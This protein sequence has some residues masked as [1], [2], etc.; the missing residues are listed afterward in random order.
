MISLGVGLLGLLMAGVLAGILGGAIVA[1]LAWVGG[2]TTAIA[3]L[4]LMGLGAGAGGAVQH[5]VSQQVATGLRPTWG[6]DT[7]V[8]V[9]LEAEPFVQLPSGH[10]PRAVVRVRGGATAP[11]DEAELSVEQVSVR[12]GLAE[13]WRSGTHLEHASPARVSLRLGP[14]RLQAAAEQ[15]LNR[16][17]NQ[18]GLRISVPLLGTL[19]PTLT[20]LS[21]KA[22]APAGLVFGADL[23]GLP[24]GF[25]GPLRAAGALAMSADGGA[26]G[27]ML[28]E[29][30]VSGKPM[31]RAMLS[32]VNAGLAELLMARDLGLP[33]SDWRF[34]SVE[35]TA[36]GS[37]KLS[38][39]GSVGPGPLGAK[40]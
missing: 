19:R 5:Q 40:P 13:A 28:G 27:V 37:L 25:S 1:G 3:L 15:G 39:V 32:M 17:V 14:A 2:P 26:L 36:D 24:M 6:Q 35:G 29:A 7:Q 30:Q 4:A 22:T 16:L 31:P 11:V 12:G 21:L 20:N 33:G 8:D 23:K 38:L 10:V 18:G 34:E 9:R